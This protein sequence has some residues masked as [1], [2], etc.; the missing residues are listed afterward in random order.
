MKTKHILLVLAW[1]IVGMV[2]VAQANDISE[3]EQSVVRVFAARQGGGVSMGT[4]SVVSNDGYVLTNNHVVD[5][6]SKFF[7]GSQKLGKLKQG[8]L[9][10]R[11]EEVDLA[12]LQIPN[13]GLR[14]IKITTV[15]PK[16]GER[17]F[18]IGFPG[19]ADYGSI[20]RIED[21]PLDATFTDGVLSR[22]FRKPW[23][24]RSTVIRII[25]HNADINKGNSGGPLVDACGRVIGVNTQGKF[26]HK[27][28]PTQ[29]IF[30]S[31]HIQEAV[32]Y[33]DRAGVRYLMESNSCVTEKG[34]G[35]VGPIVDNKARDSATKAEKAA[36][37]ATDKARTAEEKAKIA[38]LEATRAKQA[39]LTAEKMASENYKNMLIWVASL[40]AIT[41]VALVFALRKPRERVVR[42]IEEMAAPL[43]RR[44]R[45][46]SQR[47]HV[48]TASG[49]L[50]LTGFGG[51]GRP[52]RIAMEDRILDARAQG[53]VIG[54]H[55]EQVDFAIADDT[56]SRRHAKISRRNGGYI[57]EDMN[58]SNGTHVGG[59]MLQAYTPM[60]I[61][62]GDQVRLGDVVLQTSTL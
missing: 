59:R 51:D 14:P 16:K 3:V 61:R 27:S 12:I 15:L 48:P 38:E 18:A 57:L 39:A 1:S 53:M 23:A 26:I 56:I 4:G 55:A 42:V 19:A 41:L 44:I 35:P 10:W 24:G 43:S 31:S 32:P 29:G 2:P 11:S 25:Q 33:L 21:I 58:S 54:R 20:R 13:L 34:G 17:V 49:G 9:V 6:G 30:Y 8:R 47:V 46:S 36:G 7:V 28:L 5:G 45:G 52:I 50:V 62:P 40:G 22:L 37:A 60:E